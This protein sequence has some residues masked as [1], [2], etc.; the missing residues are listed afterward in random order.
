MRTLTAVTLLA[1]VATLA[2][3]EPV[4]IT[5]RV[6][7]PDG[8]AVAGA[9]VGTRMRTATGTEWVETTSG[10]DG[11]F[12]L[13]FDES[14]PRS[15]YQVVAVAAGLSFG[16]ARAEAGGDVEIALPA[17]G[18]PITGTVVDGAGAPVAGAEAFVQHWRAGD[19][20]IYVGDWR[21]LTSETDADGRFTIAGLPGG[22][23]AAMRVEAEG[24][25]EQY[26]SVP[27][28][29]PATGSDVTITLQPEATIAG[30]VSRDGE[31]VAEVK[32]AAQA[33]RGSGWGEDRTGAEGHYV[34]R[35]LPADTYNVAL[36]APEG[37]TAVAHE[38]VK[39]EAGQR[40]EGIHFA[41]IEGSL[42]QGTVTWA[43]TGQPV[44][45]A[46]IGAY[47][48]AHPRSG[49]WVQ[50][51]TTDAQGRYELRLPPGENYVYW[52]GFPEEAWEAAPEG[53]TFELG[54][55]AHT[56]DFALTRKPTIM[57]T[58]LLPD[59]SAAAG[60]PVLW[61][62]GERQPFSRPDPVL[63]DERGRVSLV[64]GRRMW[65]RQRAIAAAVV[66]DAE[67]D[68]AGAALIDAE[69]QREAT[70]RLAQGAY[71]T[72]SVST[73][74]GEAVPEVT[75]RATAEPEGRDTQLPVSASTDEQGD[76]RLGPL[77]PGLPLMI[78]PDWNYRER[79]VWPEIQAFR[80]TITL[81]PGET[82]ELEPWVVAPDGLTLRG[83]VVDGD[84]RPVE[85]AFA[86]CSNALRE[87]EAQATTDA[88]GRFE[89]TGISP[90]A[91]CIVVAYSPDLQTAFALP[92]DPRVAYEPT[93]ALMPVGDVTV[94]VVDDGAPI[95]AATAR[96][97]GDRHANL[98][99][100]LSL[101]TQ[102]APVDAAGKLHVSGLVPG[103]Q[104]YVMA[105]VG[106]EEDPTLVGYQEASYLADEGHV[107][108]TMELMTRAEAEAHFRR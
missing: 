89:L 54:E 41:L 39:T 102:M 1:L 46:M 13:Q 74:E 73:I 85:G 55:E 63:T 36:T 18:E 93:F 78:G 52:M 106:D 2:A 69:A 58:V 37:L 90:G 66:S 76:F 99:E 98:P 50:N 14:R 48:P 22:A 19:S 68:L 81:E 21:P 12:T 44:E 11:A 101:G 104:Y 33:Q 83:R 105:L 65:S 70:I 8:Q 25:A 94:T 57:L 100:G 103:L 86:S 38:G 59:G 34:L 84:G 26:D 10:A 82:D 51:T 79:V 4:T 53:E 27:E 40:V 87:A 29:W 3:A 30:R 28:N 24:F 45:G 35:G 15:V 92:C 32:V 42:V 47:G 96:V 108:V 95:P 23:R 7:G 6:V 60:V 72:G 61:D 17:I 88:D 67:R 49:G 9:H 43:D 5:G 31:P 56:I 80:E 75:V 107:E 77:P 91:E 97:Y 20:G 62:G 71:V 64:F 16:A